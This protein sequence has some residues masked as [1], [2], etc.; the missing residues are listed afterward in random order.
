MKNSIPSDVWEKKKALIAKLYKEEEWP[1]KQVIKKI[2]SDNFNPSETQLRSRLKKWR[3]TKPSR[4]T[5]KKSPDGQFKA[6]DGDSGIDGAS[7]KTQNSSVSPRTPLHANQQPAVRAFPATEPDWYMSHKVYA[8]SQGTSGPIF[9]DDQTMSTWPLLA[10]QQPSPS[11][12]DRHTSHNG[13]PVAMSG[14]NAFHQRRISQGMDTAFV[15]ATSTVTHT[16]SGI[17]FAV[18]TESCTPEQV[19]TTAATAPVQWTVPHWYPLPPGA[20]SQPPPV[21]FYPP[22]PPSPPSTSPVDPTMQAP[23]SQV[24]F[25]AYLPNYSGPSQYQVFENFDGVKSWKRVMSLQYTPDTTALNPGAERPEVANYA[26]RKAS[27]PSKMS[28]YHSNGLMTPPSQ[29]LPH[30]QNPMMCGPMYSYLGPDP[31]PHRPPS[32]EF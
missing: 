32:I 26:D 12:S 29:F 3:V 18:T 6:T 27:L 31:L 21:Q 4:Q 10:D 28:S 7:P 5:R 9:V 1:L 16:F 23:H 20:I 19:S 17:P 13:S 14:S 24:D 8:P 30:V 22:A 15:N 25:S 2:R 11:P